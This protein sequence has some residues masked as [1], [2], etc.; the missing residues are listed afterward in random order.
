MQRHKRNV[1]TSFYYQFARD[2]C[3]FADRYADG[4]LISVLEGT[5]AADS[6]YNHRSL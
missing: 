6:D 3:A 5:L 4:R 1:P 2:A